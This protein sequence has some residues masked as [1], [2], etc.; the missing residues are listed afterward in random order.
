MRRA[1]DL[2]PGEAKTDAR[3]AFVIADAARTMPYTL[4]A[5]DSDDEALAELTMLTGY[6]NDL[7]GE[8]NRTTNR[9]R[10]LLAQ[11]LWDSVA[12]FGRPGPTGRPLTL[13]AQVTLIESGLTANRATES[14][15]YCA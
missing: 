9:L 8:V 6:D 5:V 14:H 13:N 10:G 7:A 2:Y 15:R 4:R 12:R 3:D 11:I 1:A